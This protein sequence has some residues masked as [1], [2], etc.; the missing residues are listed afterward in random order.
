MCLYSSRAVQFN[1]LASYSL[2]YW[3][4]KKPAP[5]KG[6]IPDTTMPIHKLKIGK[7]SHKGDRKGSD[8]PSSSKDSGEDSSQ[9]GPYFLIFVPS[10]HRVNCTHTH[11]QAFEVF[12]D[13][14]RQ[15][16][17][18]VLWEQTRYV[19]ANLRFCVS[20]YPYFEPTNFHLRLKVLWSLT[21]QQDFTVFSRTR[22]LQKCV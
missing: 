5:L 3:C 2:L 16:C 6:D 14:K 9:S 7:K 12:D 22:T 10:T 19:A 11:A 1:C 18:E 8:A 20:N 4:E 17:R 15:F 21:K 13:S